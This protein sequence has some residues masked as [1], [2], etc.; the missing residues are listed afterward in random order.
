MDRAAEP[1]LKVKRRRARPLQP[2]SAA[3]DGWRGLQD[4]GKM[5]VMRITNYLNKTIFYV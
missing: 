1:A 4:S 2:S 5:I 3:F